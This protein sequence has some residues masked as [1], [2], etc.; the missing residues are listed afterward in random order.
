VGPSAGV[1]H[2]FSGLL[3]GLYLLLI[4]YQLFVAMVFTTSGA[5]LRHTQLKELEHLG[6][7]LSL[8]VAPSLTFELALVFSWGQSIATYLPAL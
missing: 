1:T 3:A 7:G 5:L 4:L 8:V 6:L 2:D